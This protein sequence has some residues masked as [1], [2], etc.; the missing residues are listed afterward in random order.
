MQ[1]KWHQKFDF[2]TTLSVYH[3]IFI[4]NISVVILIKYS[5]I[6]NLQDSGLSSMWH[7]IIRIEE[8]LNEVSLESTTALL[9]IY[10]F[11][12]GVVY[13]RDTLPSNSPIPSSM[14]QFII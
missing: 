2:K 5:N 8:L 3:N 9:N 6:Y 10:I 12:S 14:K 11:W 1:N 13:I 7:I 4:I